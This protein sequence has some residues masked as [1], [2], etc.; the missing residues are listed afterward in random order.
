MWDAENFLLGVSGGGLSGSLHPLAQ[1]EMLQV[2]LQ[3][4]EVV[5]PFCVLELL[6]LRSL[7]LLLCSVANNQVGGWGLVRIWVQFLA[8]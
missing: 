2:P 1:Q 5:L 8:P 3:P 6:Q 7:A 4:V